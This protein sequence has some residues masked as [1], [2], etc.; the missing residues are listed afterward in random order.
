MKILS[1]NQFPQR[2][3]LDQNFYANYFMGYHSFLQ[4]NNRD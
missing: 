3:N 1:W 4:T 2:M